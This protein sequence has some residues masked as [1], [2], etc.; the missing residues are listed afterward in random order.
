MGHQGKSKRAGAIL[1]LE[2]L[3]VFPIMM[4]IFFGTVEFGL[5][6]AAEARLMNAS[7]EGT[8]VAAAAP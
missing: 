6:L 4:A 2:L 8:R 5:L 3:F 7:R 1:A